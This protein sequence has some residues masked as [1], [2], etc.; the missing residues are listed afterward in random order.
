M[1]AF[2]PHIF[3]KQAPNN[4]GNGLFSSQAIDACTEIFRIDR[5]LVSVLDS[6]HLKDACSN[7][8]VWVPDH[9]MGQMGGEQGRDVKLR[10]CQGCK[11]SRY[12][13]KVGRYYA[14]GVLCICFSLFSRS[15]VPTS[16]LTVLI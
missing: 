2:P 3:T 16:V 15:Y 5:P 13:T 4:A 9:G 14:L 12:C 7:C 10:A 11:I 6:R 8:Y 1:P